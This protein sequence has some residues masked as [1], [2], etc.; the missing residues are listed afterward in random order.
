MSE[1]DVL[2]WG[3]GFD[4]VLPQSLVAF[5]II[6]FYNPAR[7]GALQLSR[8]TTQLTKTANAYTRCGRPIA[9]GL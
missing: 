4:A 5:R 1:M 7:Q 2:V 3:G 9:T 8:A 6:C